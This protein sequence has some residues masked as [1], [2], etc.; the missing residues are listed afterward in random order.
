MNK[1]VKLYA[2]CFS[3]IFSVGA[4]AQQAPAENKQEILNPATHDISS[5]THYGQTIYGKSAF[6]EARGNNEVGGQ[7]NGQVAGYGSSAPSGREA[8]MRKLEEQNKLLNAPPKGPE[9]LATGI[10][11]GHV[12]VYERKDLF[13]SYLR[14]VIE[15][16]TPLHVSSKLL[17]SS[18]DLPQGDLMVDVA[19]RDENNIRA[20]GL[21]IRLSDGSHTSVFQSDRGE[22][23]QVGNL[24]QAPIILNKDTFMVGTF[25]K[26]Q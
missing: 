2:V 15:N 1:F 13:T 24:V 12:P 9:L 5:G 19:K 10:A 22:N 11:A 20:F 3:A 8:E 4:I 21:V 26:I 18:L 25:K 7:D 17:T 16:V 6:Q 14:G 23:F